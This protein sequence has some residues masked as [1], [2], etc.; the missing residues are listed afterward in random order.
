MKPSWVWTKYSAIA[1][2][3]GHLDCAEFTRHTPQL[4]DLYGLLYGSV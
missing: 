2:S 1:P 4:H 3:A